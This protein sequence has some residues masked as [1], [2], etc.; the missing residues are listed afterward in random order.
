MKPSKNAY[1]VKVCYG[2]SICH[3]TDLA[4]N[5]VWT[6]LVIMIYILFIS[7]LQSF[8][9]PADL[10]QELL[11]V[12]KERLWSGSRTIGEANIKIAEMVNKNG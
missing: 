5:G 11:L 3:K 10:S 4:N 12:V 9:F 2:S 6:D 1:L 8:N 7:L